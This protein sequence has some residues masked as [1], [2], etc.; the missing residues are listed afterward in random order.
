MKPALSHK[1]FSPHPESGD[2]LLPLLSLLLLILPILIGHVSFADI[3]LAE[4]TVPQRTVAGTA[5]RSGPVTL[6]H[7]QLGVM[8]N[9]TELVEESTGRRLSRLMLTSDRSAPSLVRT[10][11]FRLRRNRPDLDVVL[12]EAQPDVPY[13]SFVAMLTALQAPPTDGSPYREP[14]VIVVPS[15]GR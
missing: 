9:L 14:Q 5:P 7:V 12:V 13:E 1:S 8:E 10:E 3:T 4:V 6:F 2:P 15:G 11:F